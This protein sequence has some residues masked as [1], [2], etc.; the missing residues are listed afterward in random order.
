MPYITKIRFLSSPA[1]G[2]GILIRL[3][4][5][6]T[7]IVYDVRWGGFITN[8]KV[9]EFPS[10]LVY[11]SGA[12]ISFKLIPDPITDKE[13]GEM[14]DELLRLFAVDK[15]ELSRVL[16]RVPA[17]DFWKFA[18]EKEQYYMLG[19]KALVGCMLAM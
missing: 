7:A 12:S 11:K 4:S 15:A 19:A 14:F 1:L 8:V 9:R 13:I 17:F 3:D 6:N 18:D 2:D 16:R 10:Q 5:T